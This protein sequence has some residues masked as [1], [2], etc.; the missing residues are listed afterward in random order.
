LIFITAS[1]GPIIPTYGSR[2][3]YIIS[4]ENK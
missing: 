2:K 1:I 4:A 3:K